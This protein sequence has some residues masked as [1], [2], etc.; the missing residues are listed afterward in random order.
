MAA[1]RCNAA[2]GR[3]VSAWFPPHQRGLATGIRQT[4]QPLGIAL[5]ALVMPELTERK[6][7]SALMFPAVWCKIAAI[8][9]GSA[10]STRR[11]ISPQGQSRGTV[12]F[13]SRVVRSVEDA[14]GI[15][16][17]DIAA[18]GDGDVHAGLANELL[19]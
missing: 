18:D 6:P 10:S 11:G 1:A 13:V 2:G 8:A 7:I 17:D 19:S 12:Q 14:H 5:G 4:A 9:T 3:L 16:T 15:G